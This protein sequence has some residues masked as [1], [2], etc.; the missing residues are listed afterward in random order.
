VVESIREGKMIIEDLTDE[1]FEEIE[2]QAVPTGPSFVDQCR[3]AI[4]AKEDS[5]FF[6]EVKTAV[7]KPHYLDRL[8]ERC[9]VDRSGYGW[10]EV[11]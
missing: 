1:A 6:D 8:R 3:Q 5:G 11:L 2:I 9:R 10:P 4:K 7:V